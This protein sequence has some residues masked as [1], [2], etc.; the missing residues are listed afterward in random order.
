MSFNWS[1][2]WI[3]G[4]SVSS[5]NN[6]NWIWMPQLSATPKMCSLL[7]L[8]ITSIPLSLCKSELHQR[9]ELLFSARSVWTNCMWTQSSLWQQR[10][11][12]WHSRLPHRLAWPWFPPCRQK[13][14]L[15]W[16]LRWARADSQIAQ[17]Q[18]GRLKCLSAQRESFRIKR[19]H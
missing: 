15:Q 16:E 18:E 10:A 4:G 12:R 17:R 13:S 1:R 5:H 6:E 11:D 19:W 9:A 7:H 14:V 2:W 3:Q 8:A